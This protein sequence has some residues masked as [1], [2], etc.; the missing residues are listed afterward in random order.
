M[1]SPSVTKPSA[2]S[3]RD[4]GVEITPE[5]DLTIPGSSPCVIPNVSGVSAS[6]ASPLIDNINVSVK[7]LDE[8]T[9]SALNGHALFKKAEK[10]TAVCDFISLSSVSAIFSSKVVISDST[11]CII[12]R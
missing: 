11:A 12:K 8:E 1:E 5:Y 7:V 9:L 10:I 2:S 4:V 6:Y 3:D